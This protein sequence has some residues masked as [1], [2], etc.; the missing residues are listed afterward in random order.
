MDIIGIRRD[1]RHNHKVYTK[2]TT[3]VMC[4]SSC[5]NSNELNRIHQNSESSPLL[6]PSQQIQLQQD[7]KKKKKNS[8]PA[9]HAGHYL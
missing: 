6:Q 8:H 7:K 2:R 1:R 9:P 4:S 5:L 3:S